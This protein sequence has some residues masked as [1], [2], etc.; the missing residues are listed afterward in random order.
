MI[1]PE[2]GKKIAELRKQKGMTQEELAY[3][4]HVNV[5]SIQR[6]ESGEVTPR[7]STLELLSEVFEL[8]LRVEKDTGLNLWLIFMHF[9]SVIPFIV[10]PLMIWAWK[11]DEIP[12]MNRHGMDV[13][14]FQISMFIYLFISAIL[15][16]VIIGE[17][18]LLALIIKGI[19]IK[20]MTLLKCINISQRLE[21][22]S[23]STLNSSSKTSDS[24]SRVENLGVTS[25]DSIL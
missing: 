8:E 11:K 19:T 15:V 20:G 14:N 16:L 1:Q 10:I 2:I 4:S 5:R 22:V 24:N 17:F 25:P 7:F 21:P 9:S 13:L 6:I 18:L 3:R 12:E 23:F